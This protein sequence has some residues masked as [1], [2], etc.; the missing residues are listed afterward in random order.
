MKQNQNKQFWIGRN[1]QMEE[2]G[3][4][5][6]HKDHINTETHSFANTKNAWKHKAWNRNIYTKDK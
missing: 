1:K 5:T 6:K 2:K 3:S 4:K